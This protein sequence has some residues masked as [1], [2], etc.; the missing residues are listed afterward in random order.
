MNSAKRVSHTKW[1]KSL[2]TEYVPLQHTEETANHVGSPTQG[3]HS[4]VPPPL[5]IVQNSTMRHDIV[6]LQ[7]IIFRQAET[8]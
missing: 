7:D 6:K 8:K 4:R 5:S 1:K 2:N 3:K